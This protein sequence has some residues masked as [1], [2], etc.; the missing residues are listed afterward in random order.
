MLYG[1]SAHGFGPPVHNLGNCSGFVGTEGSP[2]PHRLSGSVQRKL[3]P[4][5]ISGLSLTNSFNP[6][7]K[8]FKAVG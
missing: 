7:V 3:N 5:V 6:L 1:N 4:V 2:N 8:R